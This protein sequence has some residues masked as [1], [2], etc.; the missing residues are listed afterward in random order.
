MYKYKYV[1][2]I[3]RMFVS[4]LVFLWQF[5]LLKFS[6]LVLID[7][8]HLTHA[9]QCETV[10]L[11]LSVLLLLVCLLLICLLFIL[12]VLSAEDLVD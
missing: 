1:D 5:G 12:W 7:S 10:L 2:V 4:K 3:N 8:H 11:I 9:R 6:I